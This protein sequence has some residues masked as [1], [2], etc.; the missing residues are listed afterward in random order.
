MTKNDE[1]FFPNFGLHRYFLIEIQASMG[2]R[3]FFLISK[4]FVNICFFVIMCR[5]DNFL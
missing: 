5:R 4:P 1:E 3:Q 2:I